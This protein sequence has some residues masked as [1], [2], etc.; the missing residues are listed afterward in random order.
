MNPFASLV[1]SFL[2][3]A[4]NLLIGGALFGWLISRGWVTAEQA[5]T[6]WGYITGSQTFA[7][8]M[9]LLASAL[10]TLLWGWFVKLRSKL[11]F[12]TALKVPPEVQAEVARAIASDLP[13]TLALKSPAKAEAA[14]EIAVQKSELEPI[15][16]VKRIPPL[17]VILFFL[18]PSALLLGGCNFD[19]KTG[20]S[21][22]TASGTRYGVVRAPATPACSDPHRLREVGCR[23]RA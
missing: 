8:V 7:F 2:R 12:L 10:A 3:W 17:R 20:I 18:L 4:F 15:P 16:P 11:K 22:T 5:Q 6:I 19:G 23:T 1:G 9:T 13:T 14:V 21:I